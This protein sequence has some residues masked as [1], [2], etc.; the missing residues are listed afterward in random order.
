MFATTRGMLQNGA[1]DIDGT[2]VWYD[3]TPFKQAER[4]RDLFLA[5]VSHELRTPLSAILAWA[6]T[7]QRGSR[8]DLLARGLAAIARNVLAPGLTEES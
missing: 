7:L 1:D 3:V 2:V 8:P 4:Q 5:A 6:E